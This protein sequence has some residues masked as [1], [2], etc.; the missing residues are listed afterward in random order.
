MAA[1][2]LAAPALLSLETAG[3]RGLAHVVLHAVDTEPLVMGIRDE[4][5]EAQHE[6]AELLHPRS[7]YA[8]GRRHRQCQPRYRRCRS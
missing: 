2:V 1:K 3:L 6:G 7:D 4:D 8:S 5:A